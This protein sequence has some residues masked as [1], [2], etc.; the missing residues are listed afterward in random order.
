M[1]R[2]GAGLGGAAGGGVRSERHEFFGSVWLHQYNLYMY[3]Y[4]NLVKP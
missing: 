4:I 2:G 1:G 3:V